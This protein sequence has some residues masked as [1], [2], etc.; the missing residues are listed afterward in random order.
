MATVPVTFDE[1]A[2]YY[3]V[4]FTTNQTA[5]LAGYEQTA[6]RMERLAAAHDGFL[7]IDSARSDVGIT[8]SYWRDEASIAAWKSESEHT[9]ARETGRARWYERYTLRV[10]R[11]EREYTWHRS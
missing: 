5:D 11:V 8:V 6:A 9:L 2:G 7:G 4:I 10:A 3:A 1:P